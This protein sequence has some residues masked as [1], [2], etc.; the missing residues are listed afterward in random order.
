MTST[1][2]GF[3]FLGGGGFYSIL[4]FAD[5]IVFNC[6]FFCSFLRIEV[7]RVDKIGHFLWT[8]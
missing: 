2:K 8:S 3:F 7:M 5:S 1:W 6:G 4:E